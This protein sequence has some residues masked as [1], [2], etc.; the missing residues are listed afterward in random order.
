[1]KPAQLPPL[2]A[3]T[4]GQARL[5]LKV[6]TNRKSKKKDPWRSALCV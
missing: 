3:D 2:P 4:D 1:M 6:E 5:R